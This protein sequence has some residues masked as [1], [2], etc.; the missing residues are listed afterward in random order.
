M[1]ARLEPERIRASVALL[2]TLGLPA[3]V[4]TVSGRVVAANALL[5]ALQGQVTPRAFGR[6]GF[7]EPAADALLQAVLSRKDPAAGGTSIPLSAVEERPPAV[8]HGLPMRRMAR[9][10]FAN[11]HTLV[12]VTP[13]TEDVVPDAD[14]LGGLFDLTPAEARVAR[15][16]AEGRTLD[17]IAAAAGT[18]LASVRTQLRHVMGKTGTSRQA[19]IVNLLAGARRIAPHSGAPRPETDGAMGEGTDP[20]PAAKHRGAKPSPSLHKG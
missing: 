2:A 16:L 9:D 6:L 19:E 17:H 10:F 15:G 1:A 14:L 18:P 7:H 3:A 11:A 13:L 12:V 20:V 5:D 4:L 8:A